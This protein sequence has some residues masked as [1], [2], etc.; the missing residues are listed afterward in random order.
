MHVRR[1]LILLLVLPAL[2]Y[3]SA[4]ASDTLDLDEYSGK[5]IPGEKD[6][7]TA[8]EEGKVLHLYR[9][10]LHLWAEPEAAS[11]TAGFDDLDGK[12]RDHPEEWLLR[13][14]LL[15]CLRKVGEGESLQQRLRD[16]LLEIEKTDPETLP[17]TTGLRYLEL[18]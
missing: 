3:V 17:I 8:A 2:S 11:L 6:P 12:L 1:I 5:K 4:S 7:E 9:E 18:A 13:W 16:E 14:N 15:E 10:A